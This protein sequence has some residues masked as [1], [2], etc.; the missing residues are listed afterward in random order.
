MA[1]VGHKTR[2][3][4]ERDNIRNDDRGAL[5]LRGADLRAG[6]PRLGGRTWEIQP[7]APIVQTLPRLLRAGAK[8][9]IWRLQEPPVGP[10]DHPRMCIGLENHTERRERND[11]T[12]L[13]MTQENHRPG[14]TS[15]V[16]VAFLA[17]RVSSPEAELEDHPDCSRLLRIRSYQTGRKRILERHPA[18]R[19]PHHSSWP[20]ARRT[21]RRR[22]PR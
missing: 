15:K 20:Y 3:V 1:V 12:R 13:E 22:G 9:P 4:F 10:A 11:A 21:L 8:K 17:A 2:T 19:L 7:S 16:P 14:A 5:G 6:R 18:H